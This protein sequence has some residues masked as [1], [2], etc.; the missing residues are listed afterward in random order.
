MSHNNDGSFLAKF[1]AMQQQ[2]GAA[3][4]AAAAV[5]TQPPQPIAPPQPVA[6]VTQND[7]NFLARFQ[8]MQKQGQPPPQPASA[9]GGESSS[10][11]AAASAAPKGSTLKFGIQPNQRVKRAAVPAAF[12]SA[13]PAES[14]G[15][16]DPAALDP[17]TKATIEKCANWVAQNG[18]MFEQVLKKK[19][20]GDPTFSFLFDGKQNQ[21]AAKCPPPP[22]PLPPPTN[23][24]A[25]TR[26]LFRPY[27]R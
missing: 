24:H 10:K 4:P 5:V 6:P 18:D 26:T 13:D 17:K 27:E 7:G 25:H 19:N 22:Y 20:A 11:N 21:T 15:D 9:A 23:I 3:A 14:T 2:Q 12:G 1:M 16:E 8:E